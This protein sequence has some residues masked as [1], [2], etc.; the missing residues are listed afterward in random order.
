M[1][2]AQIPATIPTPNGSVQGLNPIAL[3]YLPMSVVGYVG[4]YPMDSESQVIARGNTYMLSPT[5][6]NEFRASYAPSNYYR[7]LYCAGFFQGEIRATSNLTL[8]VGRRYDL[9]GYS[10]NRIA[11]LQGRFCT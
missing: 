10:K 9:Y 8:S 11:A 6:I 7:D 5:M 3:Y 4:A 2:N 1:A